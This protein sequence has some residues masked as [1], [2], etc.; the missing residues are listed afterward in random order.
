L[1]AFARKWRPRLAAERRLR[2]ERGFSRK[3]RLAKRRLAERRLAERWFTEWRFTEW[4]FAEWRFAE[5]RFAE[6]RFAEWRLPWRTRTLAVWRRRA[7]LGT[8]ASFPVVAFL[9]ELGPPGFLGFLELRARVL[10]DAAGAPAGGAAVAAAQFVQLGDSLVGGCPHAAALE[11]LHD[12]LGMLALQ[13]LQRRHQVVRFLG[14]E[15]RG[16]RADQ[17]CPVGKSA[18]ECFLA[19][20]SSPAPQASSPRRHRRR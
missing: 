16:F 11:P 5:W 13:L 19:E 7:F 20:R 12:R 18:H 6:W 10:V 1:W 14:A 9:T 4:R 2:T 15:R 3:R 8:P 17:N